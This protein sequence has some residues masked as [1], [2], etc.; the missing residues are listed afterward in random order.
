[1]PSS[2]AA[3]PL[4]VDVE[5][6]RLQLYYV[7]T[8]LP[9]TLCQLTVFLH[10]FPHHLLLMLSLTSATAP[11]TGHRLKL[12]PCLSGIVVVYLFYLF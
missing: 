11:E 7:P 9:Y 12:L 8:L 5:V 10:I 4:H 6:L 2:A 1:M 3:F